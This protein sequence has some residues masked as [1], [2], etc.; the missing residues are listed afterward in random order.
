MWITTPNTG[1]LAKNFKKNHF[2]KAT[3]GYC[4]AIL[5]QKSKDRIQQAAKEAANS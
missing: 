1:E 2:F 3:A 5:K 4:S